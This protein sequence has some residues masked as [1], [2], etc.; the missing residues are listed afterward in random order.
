[1][2]F[3]K[4]A[5]YMETHE[6]ARKEQDDVYVMGISDFAQDQLGDIVYVELPE[7]GDA[8]EKGDQFIVVESVKAA[9]DVYA[10][11]SGEIV[12]VNEALED[13]PELVNSD[14]FGDGWLIKIKASDPE[15]WEDL[16][17][18]GAYKEVVEEEQG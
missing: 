12:E 1:M 17:E 16:M 13:E 10:P 3:D 6:W 11:L 2:N 14:P 18:I 8:I 4:Q 9:G 15:E 7:V 5:R